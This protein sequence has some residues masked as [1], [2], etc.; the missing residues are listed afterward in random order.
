MPAYD[1]RCNACS[2]VF[3]KTQRITEPAG[4]ACPACGGAEC[5]RLITGGTFH[6][7]G[8]GWYASDYGPKRPAA[9]DTPAAVQGEPAACGALPDGTCAKA[10]CATAGAGAAA[11]DA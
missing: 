2:A 11:A 10:D 7:K 9:V 6:L 3:E 5:T 1:Y 8:A 4:A